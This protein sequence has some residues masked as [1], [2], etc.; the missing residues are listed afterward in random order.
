MRNPRGAAGGGDGD[1]TEVLIV[2]DDAD[3]CSAI[4]DSL[5]MAGFSVT[6]ALTGKEAA[7]LLDRGRFAV[8]VSDIRLPG[9]S[10]NDLARRALRCTP[11]PKV[12][13]MT[14]FPDAET[15]KEAYVA[16]AAHFL[17]KP[18]SLRNLARVVEQAALEQSAG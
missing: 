8:V 9:M 10:G 12:V 5:E 7:D 1:P 15:V 3:M 6:T 2:E 18:L 14:A 16:G 17:A 11:P 4:R 13:L